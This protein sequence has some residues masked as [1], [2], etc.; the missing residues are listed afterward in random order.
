MSSL[1]G[2]Y[3]GPRRGCHLGGGVSTTL[4]LAIIYRVFAL[5]CGGAEGPITL[6]GAF[7]SCKQCSVVAVEAQKLL[8]Q[9]RKSLTTDRVGAK[10]RCR[11][12]T[13]SE[14]HK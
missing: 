11:V 10:P 7:G 13:D 5:A 2:Y 12:T 8:V 1:C 3:M 14:R 9:H 4:L 6:C